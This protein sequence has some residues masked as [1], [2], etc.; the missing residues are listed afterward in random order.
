LIH[1]GESLE[2][3]IGTKLTTKMSL[4]IIP[5]GVDA[6]LYCQG[7]R[8]EAR[9]RMGWDA[10]REIFVCVGRLSPN[11]KLDPHP[12]LLAFREAFP[13]GSGRPMLAL[14]GDDTEQRIADS[15]RKFA[16]E[17][18]LSDDVIVRPNITRAEKLLLYQASD[19]FVSPSDNLQETFGCSLLEAMSCGLPVIASDWSGYRDIVV[20]R[21]TGFLIRTVWAD[22]RAHPGVAAPFTADRDRHG[23]IAQTVAFDF[24]AMVNRLRELAESEDLRIRMG[25]SAR[26]RV[27]E[28][29]TWRSVI[30]RHEEA[31]QRSLALSARNDARV[32]PLSAGLSAYNPVEIF[33]HYPTRLLNERDCVAITAMGRRRLEGEAVFPGWREDTGEESQPLISMLETIA[34]AGRCT[35]RDVLALAPARGIEA[36][37]S[38]SGS[39]AQ[40]QQQLRILLRLAK[41]GLVELIS[42]KGES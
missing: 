39:G 28:S 8:T 16:D 27:L 25:R 13:N 33:G 37:A 24:P 29:F 15:L 18:G 30:G 3:R 26:R 6:E 2:P 35:V 12:L 40:R 7:D 38:I 19:V 9:Q 17:L 23:M 5:L 11:T 34:T 14:A 36:A 22:C 4:P 10:R 21:E 32:A 31:W 41:Y 20:E 42:A 1:V